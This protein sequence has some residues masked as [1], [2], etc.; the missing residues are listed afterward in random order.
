MAARPNTS[1]R[2]LGLPRPF[3]RCRTASTKPRDP[4]KIPGSP[5][6]PATCPILA[7]P[8]I[9]RSRRDRSHSPRVERSDIPGTPEKKPASRRDARNARLLRDKISSHHTHPAIRLP[10]PPKS[11][12]THH[13]RHRQGSHG[14]SRLRCTS[15]ADATTASRATPFLNRL[16]PILLSYRPRTGEPY[17]R[18][19]FLF[20]PASLWPRVRSPPSPVPPTTPATG[21]VVTALAGCGARPWPTPPPP[22]DPPES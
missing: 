11:R 8:L 10:H 7:T 12:A 1:S 4:R 13:P 18:H 19:W 15:L 21:N 5:P 20:R 3:A 17:S 2:H 16:K 14:F 6:P 9:P 22:H